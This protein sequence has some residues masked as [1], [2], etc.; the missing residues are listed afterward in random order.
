MHTGRE[1]YQYPGGGIQ[2]EYRSGVR[3]ELGLGDA[4]GWV[5]Q[6]TTNIQDVFAEHAM[7][8]KRKHRK[9]PPSRWRRRPRP[10]LPQPISQLAKLNEEKVVPSSNCP[11]QSNCPPTQ[12]YN[13]PLTI[14]SSDHIKSAFDA[15]DLLIAP[16]LI[17]PPNSS[18][19]CITLRRFLYRKQYH[20]EISGL[21]QVS[22]DSIHCR[23]HYH[24]M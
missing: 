20:L 4:R 5:S 24:C 18:Q 3:P 2:A 8:P 17:H 11:T 6:S 9:K 14:P 15:F 13:F 10:M 7:P 19:S 12:I 21:I 22:L 16:Q 1:P 23:Y